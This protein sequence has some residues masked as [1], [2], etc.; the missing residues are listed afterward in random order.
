MRYKEIYQQTPVEVDDDSLGVE[1]TL[2]DAV[3]QAGA[4][5]YHAARIEAEGLDAEMNVTVY[6]R[7]GREVVGIDRGWPGKTLADP[8]ADD[9]TG[10]SRFSSLTPKQQALYEPYARTD[11]AARGRVMTPEE[12]F[13]SQTISERTTFD[14]VT[15]ALQRSQLSDDE[16]NDL[17]TV[18]DI[19]AGLER[20]AGQGRG[21]DQQFRL[22][23][24]L[25]PNAVETLERSTQFFEDHLNT[26]YHVGYPYSFRQEGNVP[27][28]Q[29]SV[30]EDGLRADIDVDY[31][32]SKS[33]QAL[34]KGH[35]TSANS[36]VRA[37][38]NL[39]RHNGR[40]SGMVAWWRDVFGSLPGGQEGQHGLLAASTMEVPT[41][42]PPDRPSGA[43]IEAPEDAVQEFLTDWLVR[44][45]IDQAMAFVSERAYACVNIDDDVRSE[46]LGP[47]GARR[48]LASIMREATNVMGQRGS[49]TAAVDAVPPFDQETVLMPHAFEGEFV[50]ARMSPE[51]SAQYLCGQDGQQHTTV[52][53]HGVLFEF[54][55]EGA[56]ALGLLWAEET[57]DQWRLVSYQIFEM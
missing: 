51:E 50:M 3:I 33:P 15:H 6:L 31:R 29:V 18:F 14:A 20:L 56:A 34:F 36:D 55:Q 39:D 38:D 49:L 45:D 47:D 52:S 23:V 30:S 46:T 13:D 32:S 44:Q 37:G 57:P 22:Y 21:G 42:L 4:D 28:M 19:V 24:E 1:F 12:H 35:L 41:P 27:N 54:K 2:P 16:G 53:Y 5:S 26:V 8:T 48:E 11:A 17:G 7:G 9:D 25:Q 40:W 10:I 43:P